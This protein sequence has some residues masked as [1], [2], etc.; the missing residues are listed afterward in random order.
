MTKVIASADEA[1]KREKYLH[2]R[3]TVAMKGRELQ[4]T[5]VTALI[6]TITIGITG[7]IH[8][9]ADTRT[10]GII[11]STDGAKNWVN[12]LHQRKTVAMKGRELQ[13]NLVAA[14]IGTITI[15]NPVAA[16][17]GTI[18]IGITGRIH[19]RADTLTTGIADAV[20][21]GITPREA[22]AEITGTRPPVTSTTSMFHYVNFD[23]IGIHVLLDLVKSAAACRLF[24]LTEEKMRTYESCIRVSNYLFGF[25]VETPFISTLLL[26]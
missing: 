11:A 14:L 3:K 21:T 7:R 6:G 12:Y 8:M 2:Q 1:E 24:F 26:R 25:V 18:T 5:L 16:L 13:R 9:R 22:R 10:T 15:G 23:L 17:I 20:V 4:T 19:M